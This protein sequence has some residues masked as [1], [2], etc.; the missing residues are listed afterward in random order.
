MSDIQD[1]PF[2]KSG[3]GA[4]ILYEDSLIVS[5]IPSLQLARGHTLIIPKRHAEPPAPL[6]TEE[7]AAIMREVDRLRNLLLK[8]FGKGVDVW[9]KSRPFLPQGH[10][11]TKVD[12]LHFHVI[13]SSPGDEL[14]ETG[15]VWTRNRFSRISEQDL[16][17]VMSLLGS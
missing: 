7:A 12:H 10:N 14:Y 4:R 3:F 5:F 13:P 17:E 1:C 11:G 2:C 8:H 15:L 6:T 9:Q 16:R